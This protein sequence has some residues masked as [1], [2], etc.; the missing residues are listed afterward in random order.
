MSKIPREKRI[1]LMATMLASVLFPVSKYDSYGRLRDKAELK[2]L[3]DKATK[4]C[5]T[6]AAKVVN[7]TAIA[8][9]DYANKCNAIPLDSP[10]LYTVE[11]YLKE[12]GYIEKEVDNG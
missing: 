12:Y 1:T 8:I 9:R 5:L 6:A 2:R 3:Q 10:P 11:E 7:G 4:K